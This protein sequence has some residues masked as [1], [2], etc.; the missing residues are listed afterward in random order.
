MDIKSQIY[1]KRFQVLLH[2]YYEGEYIVNRL[3]LLK[4]EMEKEHE[5]LMDVA[6]QDLL[7]DCIRK[8]YNRILNMLLFIEQ[9]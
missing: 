9:S 8:L 7:S 1:N 6:K 4:T 5:Y 2:Q 3:L